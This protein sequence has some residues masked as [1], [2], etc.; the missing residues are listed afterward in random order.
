MDSSQSLIGVAIALAVIAV[1]S[2]VAS[3]VVV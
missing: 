1:L 3:F 2:V